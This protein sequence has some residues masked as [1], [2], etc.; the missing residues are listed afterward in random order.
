MH[1]MIA[2]LFIVPS[3]L[4]TSA[5]AQTSYQLD[6]TVVSVVQ[7]GQGHL[8]TLNNGRLVFCEPKGLLSKLCSNLTAGHGV[9]FSG[10]FPAIDSDLFA[11]GAFGAEEI[12]V[13]DGLPLQPPG[14]G[15]DTWTMNACVTSNVEDGS[16]RMITLVF[17]QVVQPVFC[18]PQGSLGDLCSGIVPGDC[19]KWSGTFPAPG[20]DLFGIALELRSLTADE[21]MP[22]GN[23]GGGPCEDCDGR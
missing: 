16:G 23:G 6:D 19:G 15:A 3:L 11:L 20:Q 8:V 9:V 17:G 2:I 5:S 12:T 21:T 10:E 7:S 1:K 4:A 13:S 18:A 14:T 22:V